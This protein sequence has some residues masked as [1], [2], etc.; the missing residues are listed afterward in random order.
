MSL[1]KDYMPTKKSYKIVV[2]IYQSVDDRTADI[3]V[4]RLLRRMQLEFIKRAKEG[5]GVSVAYVYHSRQHFA[6]RD[7]ETI[8]SNLAAFF[9]EEEKEFVADAVLTSPTGEDARHKAQPVKA[10]CIGRTLLERS[11][12]EDPDAENIFVFMTNIKNEL[13]DAEAEKITKSPRIWK[14]TD[15]IILIRP[16]E[17]R[18]RL[19]ANYVRD[20]R[21]S[22]FLEKQDGEIMRAL[23][24]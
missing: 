17:K 10:W 5:Y 1:K 4:N 21:G 23:W 9:W 22:V 16:D 6:I 20:N 3:S 14:G 12:T 18:M 15:K 24:K 7:F 13:E 8:D 2:C 19:V 11:E